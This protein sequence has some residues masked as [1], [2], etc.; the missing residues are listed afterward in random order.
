MNPPEG[1]TPADPRLLAYALGEISDAAEL[2]RLD[3]AVGADPALRDAV[4]Q[5]RE[6]SAR[7]GTMF[8]CEPLPYVNPDVI[9][10]RTLASDSSSVSSHRRRSGGLGGS[11]HRIELPTTRR[12]PMLF[13]M[14]AAVAACVAAVFLFRSDESLSVPEV[15]RSASLATTSE[16]G[17][18]ELNFSPAAARSV[19][20]L[21]TALPA[22]PGVGSG[23]FSSA[24][25]GPVSLRAG[26]ATDYTEAFVRE[27]T[28]GRR[29]PPEFTRLDGLVNTFVAGR[30]TFAGS[31]PVKIDAALTDAPWNP[32]RRLLRVTVYA[33]GV[34]G[35]VA[36]RR[37]SAEIR[38]DP[39]AVKS[40]RILGYR[41]GSAGSATASLRAGQAVTT[42]YEIEPMPGVASGVFADVAVR[43]SR[44]DRDA[45]DVESATVFVADRKSLTD[46]DSDTRFASGL[47]AYALNLGED[48][49]GALVAAAG[50]DAV[51]LD[52]AKL[53]R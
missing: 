22:L 12:S 14:G 20:A 50:D 48:P 13:G 38:F 39:E 35:D 49:A 41:D 36:A 21:A 3:A 40:W 46:T 51:R 45:R 2:A 11:S 25:T 5:H 6:L 32:E 31:R 30:S 17:A 26:A 29:P 53:V 4:A 34:A 37:A 24:S 10:S 8:V 44:V 18:S 19:A 47:A 27:V 42:L 15:S 7:L 1:L 23:A 43:Y 52:F 9:V 33:K 16:V 28:H